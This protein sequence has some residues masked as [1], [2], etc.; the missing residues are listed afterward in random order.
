MVISIQTVKYIDRIEIMETEKRKQR[1]SALAGSRP[2]DST[3]DKDLRGFEFT[4]S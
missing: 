1:L 3:A 4:N 2:S